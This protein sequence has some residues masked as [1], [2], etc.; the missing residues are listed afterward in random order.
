MPSQASASG[1]VVLEDPTAMQAVADTHDTPFSWPP[2]A[3]VGVT[4]V[5]QVVPSQPA[6]SVCV[7]SPEHVDG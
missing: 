7:T 2:P 1:D 6:A 5:D 3:G 4:W